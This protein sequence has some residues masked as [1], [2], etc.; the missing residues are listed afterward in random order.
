MGSRRV[1]IISTNVLASMPID[2]KAFTLIELLMVMGLMSA[3]GALA[4]FTS[5]DVFRGHLYHT[6]RDLLIAVLDH[7]RA[8]AMGNMCESG[9]SITC[10][11]GVAH[12]VHID[13]SEGVV[14][15]YVVFQGATY[16]KD[17]PVNAVMPTSGSL[18]LVMS[19]RS[20]ISEVI[21]Q[22]ESGLVADAG[23]VVLADNTGRVSTTTIGDEGQ[24]FW[25][26]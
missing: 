25:T 6:D 26:R 10:T 20:D 23:D 15:R 18:A 24:I 13:T 2:Q 16:D 3:L 11:R 22:P 12:G 21:F 5:L 9:G 7:A 14:Q 19:S 4:L 8:E 1:S 17:D